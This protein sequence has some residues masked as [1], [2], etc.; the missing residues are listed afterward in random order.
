MAKRIKPSLV[1]PATA[2]ESIAALPISWNESIRKSSPN[3]CSGRAIAADTASKVLS[4]EV[5]PVP[6][7]IRT[8]CAPAS[9][10]RCSSCPM[11]AG[12]SGTMADPLSVW[13]WSASLDLRMRPPS[14][15]ASVRLSEQ[16]I[17]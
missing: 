4:R 11:R 16:V 3:P 8:T 13:P 1:I 15:V 9:F 5:M 14:S 7:V 6:P 12:S 2:R 10:A 17:T